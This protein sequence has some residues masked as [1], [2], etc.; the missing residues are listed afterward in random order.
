MFYKKQKPKIIHYRNYKTFKEQ[1]FRIELDKELEKIDLNNAE[2]AEFHNELLSVLNKHAPIKYK[3]IRAN[4]SSYMTKSLRK[5]I[6]LRSRLSKKFLKTKTGESKQLYNKQQNLCVTL[7]RKAKRNYFADLDNRILK[8]NRK[9]WKTVNPLFSEK[10]YQKESITIISKDTE[11]TITKNEELAE[12]FNSFFS[13]MV[14]NLKIEYDI[15]RQANVSTHPDPVLRAIETFKYHPSILKIKEFM[16]AKG[17]SFSFGYTTQEKT[18]KT[19]QNLDKKKTCQEND[20]P[21]K[22]IKLRNDIFSYFIHHNFN[23]SL[24][25]SIFPSELK[26]ADIILI[27]KKKSKFDIENYRPVASFPFSPKLTKGVCLIECIVTLNKFF[28]NI[29]VDSDR[30]T[31]LNIAFFLW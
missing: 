28:L 20:I 16:T 1:L 31:A 30:V 13:S 4:N 29:S 12:T 15:N 19:L 5:E 26:K 11:E 8:D 6:M 27:H 14:D 23:N 9:F 24:F 25:S 17:M 18:Y 22:I 3:Y 10:A 2:L 7:L 21:M